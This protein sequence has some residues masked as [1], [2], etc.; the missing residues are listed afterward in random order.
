MGIQDRDYYRE[1]LRKKAGMSPTPKPFYGTRAERERPY[2]YPS[3]EEDRS[4]DW[5][6]NTKRPSTRRRIS[7]WLAGSSLAAALALGGKALIATTGMGNLPTPQIDALKRTVQQT[8]PAQPA[9]NQPAPA[10]VQTMTMSDPV[11]RLPT[12][13][14]P[15][16]TRPTPPASSAQTPVQA[17][18]STPKRTLQECM[19]MAGTTEIN[20]KTLACMNGK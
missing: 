13:P 19:A 14:A 18:A 4:P 16:M 15:E 5:P 8:P 10:P 12:P 6:N 17:R 9:Q 11:I 2:Y 7:R 1:E 20:N 3:V